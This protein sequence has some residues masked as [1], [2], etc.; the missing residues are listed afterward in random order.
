MRKNPIETS[1]SIQCIAAQRRGW[2]PRTKL[3]P[4]TCG[5]EMQAACTAG[6][7]RDRSDGDETL[8]EAAMDKG[9]VLR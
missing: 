5:V 9:M 2:A 1:S 3:P 4:I 8:V 7:P 6:A